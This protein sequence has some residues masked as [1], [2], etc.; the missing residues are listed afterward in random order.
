[1]FKKIIIPTI[2]AG[3]LFCAGHTQAHADSV[4]FNI[5]AQKA[6]AN[7]IDINTKPIQKGAYDY[8]FTRNG[9]NYHF[10]SDGVHFGYEWH[11]TKQEN[12]TQDHLTQ[13]PNATP[14]EKIDKQQELFNQNQE[15][16]KDRDYTEH[17]PVAEKVNN[18]YVAERF[19]QNKKSQV[20]LAN[21]NTP[22]TTGSNA[23]QVMAQRTG[24]PVSTWEHIIAK[25]SNGDP[26]AHNPSGADGIFQTMPIHGD[27]STVEAQIDAAE[28]AYNRQGLSAWGF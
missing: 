26:N 10:Y 12:P 22:G 17:V 11:D 4:D 1:M 20:Q 19:E 28:L 3:G 6:Q 24:V 8:N 13:N 18:N 21:G 5:L 2:L 27:T 7:S 14:S 25:E 15:Q 16:V 9:I 23:A